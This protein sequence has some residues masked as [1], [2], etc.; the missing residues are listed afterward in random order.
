MSMWP[1]C[2]PP[3]T[4]ARNA[5]EAANLKRA[6]RDALLAPMY[7]RL[8][9][10]RTAVVLFLPAG[11]ALLQTVPKLSPPPGTTPPGLEVTGIWNPPTGNAQFSWPASTFPEIDKIQVRGCTGGTWKNGEEVLV[12]DL[13]ATA[14]N[15]QTT[16][17][18]TVPGAIAT[19]KFFVMT[20][21][22][23]ENGGKAVKITRPTT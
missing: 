4:A 19:F 17:G 5:D 13:P 23:N 2:A 21:T 3:T 14:T 9:Q 22:G 20:T 6:E 12:D 11:S 18:L 15:Y 10:Y 7:E 1:R 16:W 8:K